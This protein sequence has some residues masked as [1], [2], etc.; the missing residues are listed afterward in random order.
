MLITFVDKAHKLVRIK[1]AKGV[2]KILFGHHLAKS[3]VV[4]FYRCPAGVKLVKFDGIGLKVF[5]IDAHTICFDSHV[6]ILGNQRHFVIRIFVFKVQSCADDQVIVFI[7]KKQVVRG[8]GNIFVYTH[9][10]DAPGL[11]LHSL[12]Q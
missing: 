9:L 3:F 5:R 12:L 4:Q 11:S 7:H 8:F 6:Y 10:D 1:L 2:G